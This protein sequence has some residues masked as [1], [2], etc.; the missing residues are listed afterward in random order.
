MEYVNMKW[1]QDTRT[2]I[3]RVKSE[4]DLEVIIDE[5]LKFRE[6]IIQKVNTA[7]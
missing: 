2:E 5:K 4:K 1:D 3:Q 7:N 6:H